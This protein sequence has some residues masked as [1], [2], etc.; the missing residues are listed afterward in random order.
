MP[1]FRSS[2][3]PVSDFF[4]LSLDMNCIAEPDGSLLA[5]N[6]AFCATLGYDEGELESL[7]LNRLIHLE[8]LEQ[9]Y[10]TVE[11]LV[12]GRPVSAFPMRMLHKDGRALHTEWNCAMRDGHIYASGRDISTRVEQQAL[13]SQSDKRYEAVARLAPVGIYYSV[14]DARGVFTNRKL[15]EMC[16][17]TL[18]EAAGQRW[19]EIIH[20]EDLGP[21]MENW[22]AKVFQ[23]KTFVGE[24]RLLLKDGSVR[25]VRQTSEPLP[26]EH[27]T[28][29]SFIGIMDDIT[30]QVIAKQELEASHRRFEAL[31]RLAPVGIFRSDAHGA[32]VYANEYLART[33][34]LTTK[35][36]NGS[37][38]VNTIHSD[39]RDTVVAR[40]QA[41]TRAREVFD[42]EYR[43]QRPDGSSRWVHTRAL[44][45]TA[46][47]GT[48]DGYIGVVSDITEQKRML[49]LLSETGRI[50]RVGGWEL[51]TRTM[52]PTFSAQAN[53]IV[54]A[55]PSMSVSL[56]EAMLVYPR[57]DRER[58]SRL[59][60]SAIETGAPLTYES[61]I[62]TL[63]GARRWVHV[64][65]EPEKENGHVVRLRGVM[66]DITDRVQAEFAERESSQKLRLLVERAPLGIVLHR[67]DG[68]YIQAN[69][70]FLSIVGCAREQLQ[71]RNHFDL[72][73]A[74][75]AHVNEEKMRSLMHT[76]SYGPLEK[77]IIRFDG[78]RVPVV[79]NGV[80]VRDDLGEEF[81]W[82]IIED[83]SLAREIENARAEHQRALYE[84][85]KLLQDSNREMEEFTYAAS[86]DLREPLRTIASFC[87]L[88]EDDI[89]RDDKASAAEDM[90]VVK[91]AAARLNRLVQDLL[92]L[93][94]SGKQEI[95][96]KPMP[97]S[98]SFALVKAALH[99]QIS[100][101]GATVEAEELPEVKG[102]P[103]H[104]ERVMQNLISNAIKYQPKGARAVVKVFARRQ[105]QMW[106]IHIQDNG[107]GI[108]PEY[109][110]RIFG[111]FKRLHGQ[112]EY[113]GS[114]IG[115]AICKKTI[116]RHGGTIRV[117]SEPGKGSAFIF[118]LPATDDGELEADL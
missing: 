3:L 47:D 34:G 65:G 95:N 110:D 17:L 98:D 90:K 89:A 59:I 107:I 20:P 43:M 101:T 22:R 42:A 29:K 26:D 94:R 96:A 97:L 45:Q 83:V 13:L 108:A 27:G 100:Q 9:F 19:M 2:T 113:E 41:C 115:L 21:L 51:D 74:E 111:A 69:D 37:G 84:A 30:D 118:T 67:M 112:H 10:S 49:A 1:G 73:P 70:A 14:G 81:V 72:V 103:V 87:E 7:G 71:G 24:H 36:F 86:H 77:D 53:E 5:V 99:T 12:Q 79:T 93:S 104:I 16:G 106:A 25:W 68:S 31:A 54:G 48:F 38:W 80:L 8:D 32:A 116:E 11:S 92:A 60:R 64:V 105:G 55:P 109:H 15:Q 85:N 88:L 78:T 23:G 102:D 52:H 76:G 44:P 66:Q 56:D 57:A 82:S 114:G 50:A 75:F 18:D 46:P 61:E 28:I 62:C 40:W 33:S 63:G 39:D 6:P 117:E 58:I 4:E 35:T 91:E